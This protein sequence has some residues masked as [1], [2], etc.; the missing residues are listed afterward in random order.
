MPDRK[1]LFIVEGDSDE[2]A[3]IKKLF[4]KSYSNQEYKIYTYRTNLHN[5][6]KCLEK[7]YP[8]FDAEEIDIRLVLRS[9]E[10]SSNKKELLSAEYTDIFLIFDFEP[11]Q[12]CPH[13]KTI[14]RMLDFFNDSTLQGK[15]FINYPMMQSYKHFKTLPDDDFWNVK[16]DNEQWKEYKKVVGSI[17]NY[18]DITRYD[19]CLFVSIATHHLKKANYIL[20][21]KY[22]VP[23]RDEYLEWRYTDIFDKQIELKNN[24]GWIYVLNTCIFILIDYNPT[25]FF[26]QLLN[27]K[28]KFFI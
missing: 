25:T 3:F 27:K 14:R 13:F 2:P 17:S 5:L 20:C 11:Q 26:Q 18:T 1:F 19:Y 12:D 24:N 4:S 15:L 28:E 21:D 16:V 7:D 6:A 9:Y 10:E 8:N 23:D 22:N